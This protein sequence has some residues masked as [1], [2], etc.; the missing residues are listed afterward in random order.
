MSLTNISNAAARL[1]S[2]LLRTFL[3]VSSCGSFSKAAGRIFRSQSAVSL[4][5]KQLEQLLGQT[6]FER[7][8]RGVCLTPVAERL[9]PVALQVVSLLDQAAAELHSSSLRGSLRL[10]IPDEYADSLLPKL[11]AQFARANP[12]VELA[13]RCSFS[14]GFAQALAAGELDIAVHAPSSAGTGA[15]LLRRE[16]TCWVESRH[17]PVHQQNPLPVALFDRDCWWRDSALAALAA[18]GRDYREVYSSESVGGI[19]AAVAAGV[20]VA[21]M[22]ED[23]LRDDFM[24]LTPQQGFPAMAESALVLQV[25]EGLDSALSRALCEQIQSAFGAGDAE[26]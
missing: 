8:G 13:V 22:G 17:H 2:D 11:I 26:V 24:R 18:S 25:R 21:L 9:R 23:S 20:A 6:L 16:K 3:Q 4:Q 12:G 5:M 19:A 10:G 7:H 14:A 15:T 1:D